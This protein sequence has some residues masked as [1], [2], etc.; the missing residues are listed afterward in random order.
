V[1]QLA[2]VSV[3]WYTWFEQGRDIQV[4]NGFLDRVARALRLDAAERET[5]FEM[6]QNRP[7]PQTIVEAPLVAPSQALA[8]SRRDL[9]A[10]LPA[11]GGAVVP[12]RAPAD[13]ESDRINQAIRKVLVNEQA[14]VAL[15]APVA[16]NVSEGR[17]SGGLRLGIALT[18]LTAFML[19]PY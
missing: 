9:P 8:F 1:A 15:P 3:T 5:L 4:S 6:A 10:A 18:V 7:A 13:S 12:M 14:R 17:V 16:E 19:L 2:G 11:S